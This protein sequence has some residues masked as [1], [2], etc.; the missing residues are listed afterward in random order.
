MNPADS[1]TLQDTDVD[2]KIVDVDPTVRNLQFAERYVIRAPLGRGGVGEIVAV[3]DDQIGR[4]IALKRLLRTKRE[5]TGVRARFIREARLQAKLDHPAI[6]PVHDLGI[7]DA[8]DVWFT[9]KKIRGATLSEIVDKLRDGDADTAAY[10]RRRLLTA[11]SNVC[12]AIDF[13]HSRGVIHRD[14]KP[15]NVM[16]GDFGEVYVLDWGIA[17]LTTA[18]DGIALDDTQRPVTGPDAPETNVGEVLGTVGYM[19]PE[20]LLGHVRVIGPY[21]DVWALGAI[22][23]ELLARQPLY[24][25]QSIAAAIAQAEHSIDSRPSTRAPHLDIPP[26]LDAICQ[27]ALAREPGARYRSA[28]AM[29]LAIERYLDG[30]RD[31]QRRREHAA[32]HLARARIAEQRGKQS[33][34]EDRTLAM[35]EINRALALDPTNADARHEMMRLLVEPPREL[36]ESAKSELAA[37]RRDGIRV[38]FR[39]GGFAFLSMYL[40][41]P[42]YLWMGIR[43]WTLTAAV[44]GLIAV[45]AVTLLWG[46]TGDRRAPRALGLT[47]VSAG[48]LIAL[49]TRVVGPFASAP[50]LAFGMAVGIAFNPAGVGIR[51]IIALVAIALVAPLVLEL[52]GV[53]SPSYR[54][55][56]GTIEVVPHMTDLPPLPTAVTLTLTSVVTIVLIGVYLDRLQYALRSAQERL[57]LHAWNVRQFLP[58]TLKAPEVA[59]KS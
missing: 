36:P 3:R 31:V 46:A 15:S 2:D 14:L 5:Q 21:T 53:I 47:V 48:L 30:D 1:P 52:T 37:T 18:D 19:A 54:F 4:E 10:S 13:A 39:V 32:V 59:N 29:H 20:Q 45:S 11:L 28:R 25:R 23:F 50:V 44:L 43:D 17:K 51:G 24:P 35:Q 26:E 9:M 34:V 55:A 6:V 38:A 58:T 16:L 42:L 27:R 40:F 49:L 8:G 7:D 56:V 33:S 22:L 57:W 12:L 41:L